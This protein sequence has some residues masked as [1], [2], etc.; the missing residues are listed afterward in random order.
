MSSTAT[1]LSSSL[2]VLGCNWSGQNCI[3]SKHRALPRPSTEEKSNSKFQD[4]GK[5]KNLD[6][7]YKWPGISRGDGSKLSKLSNLCSS[8]AVWQH[9]TRCM[10]TQNYLWKQAVFLREKSLL[11]VLKG[12]SGLLYIKRVLLLKKNKKFFPIKPV[13]LKVLTLKLFSGLFALIISK[14]TGQLCGLASG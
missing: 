14:L 2:P 8:S 10:A 11:T 7:S 6:Q 13:L 9:T 5:K 1:F 3:L 4:T 12:F